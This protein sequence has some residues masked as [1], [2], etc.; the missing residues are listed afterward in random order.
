VPISVET[1]IGDRIETPL[2][3][4]DTWA[5][6]ASE[7]TDT[8]DRSDKPILYALI[9]HLEART[10]HFRA[11]ALELATS[12]NRDIPFTD[13]EREMH[14]FIRSSPDR[15]KAFLNAMSASL[16]WTA[17]NFAR[18]CI[19]I[20]RSP[21]PLRSSTTPVLAQKTPANSTL[22]LPLPGMQPYAMILTLNKTTMVSLLLA[23]FEDA[24]TNTEITAEQA[25]AFNRQF[26]AQFAFSEH[27]RH[28]IT[29]R[30]NLFADMIWAPYEVVE[31]T[32]TKITFQR[33]DT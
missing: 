22:H 23:N 30:H 16:E 10:P 15:A 5:K 18:A 19:S 2:S 12:D 7:R 25:Q 11:T 17:D 27:V 3:R 29:E 26:V 14:A 21:I 13:E 1:V 4:S 20:F 24:F 32:E 8:L 33:R 31:D 9:R 6:I 28:L